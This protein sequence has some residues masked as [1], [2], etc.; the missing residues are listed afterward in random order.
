M[1]E[2]VVACSC[3]QRMAA[4][5]DS[6]GKTGTCV[7]CGAKVLVTAANSVPA[8]SA[9]VSQA[10]RKEAADGC[11]IRCN[12]SLR[13]AW[14]RHPADT[15]CLCDRCF[16]QWRKPGTDEP[17]YIPSP[18][19]FEK[20]PENPEPPELDIAE[21]QPSKRRQFLIF[22]GA[23]AAVMAFLVVFPFEEYVATL[24]S[25]ASPE[26]YEALSEDW[27]AR[28]LVLDAL[29]SIGLYFLPLYLV[30][31]TTKSLPN[32]RLFNNLV[33][34]GAVAVVLY[35]FSFFNLNF[36]LGILVLVAQMA[37]ISYLYALEARD[38]LAYF[39]LFLLAHPLLWGTKVLVFG[40]IGAIIT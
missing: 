16:R 11:C 25:G 22:L 6:L 21:R 10:A 17:L 15:G 3:G 33:A 14:D 38:L 12:R 18:Q 30:L 4:P 2:R 37:L 23:A 5:A 20:E 7:A 39:M 32:E 24:F 40:L 26:Q 31:H 8:G 35:L 36:Y 28:L 9:P 27:R 34:V 19:C 1:G 13:G 29:F